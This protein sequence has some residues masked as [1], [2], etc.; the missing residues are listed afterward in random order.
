MA[1]VMVRVSGMMFDV[2]HDFFGIF[3]F[4][5]SG[6]QVAAVHHISFPFLFQGR[7]VALYERTVNMPVLSV[8]F[9]LHLPGN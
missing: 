4:G 5:F 3:I 8:F 6:Y 9:M 2:C 1:G 7:H